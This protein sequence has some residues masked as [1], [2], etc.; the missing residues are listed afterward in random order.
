MKGSTYPHASPGTIVFRL[1]LLDASLSAIFMLN[2][3]SS[4]L[5]YLTG[6]ID[7]AYFVV[8]GISGLYIIIFLESDAVVVM[9]AKWFLV[10]VVAASVIEFLSTSDSPIN[11]FLCLLKLSLALKSLE[12]KMSGSSY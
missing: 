11:Y 12:T 4:L 5:C 6:E 10:P 8:L 3:V 9:T 1:W 7:Y 2:P